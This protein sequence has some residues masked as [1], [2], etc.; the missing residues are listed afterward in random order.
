MSRPQAMLA[1]SVS[2]PVGASLTLAN[3]EAQSFMYFREYTTREI[4]FNSPTRNT[5]FSMRHARGKSPSLEL[6]SLTEA[7]HVFALRQYVKAMGHLRTRLAEIGGGRQAAEIALV[8]CVLFVCLEM[9]QGNRVGALV[10]LR[11]GLSVLSGMPSQVH[12]GHSRGCDYLVVKQERQALVDQLT[13]IFA[14]LDIDTMSFGERAPVFRIVSPEDIIGIELVLPAD[15]Q[16]VDQALYILDRLN[17]TVHHVRG[18]LLELSSQSC[19]SEKLNWAVRCCLEYA[20]IRK[21][22]PSQDPAAF[23]QL[24]IL[25]TNLAQ[26]LLAFQRLTVKKGVSSDKGAAAAIL[27]EIRYFYMFFQRFTCRNYIETSYDQFNSMFE[28]IVLLC[29][30]LVDGM[31]PSNTTPLTTPE[32]TF[33]LDSGAIPSLYLTAIKCRESSIRR[34]AI[35]LLHRYP[36]QEGMWEPTMI[37]KYVEEI[38]NLEERA[39]ASTKKDISTPLK[40]KDVTEASR[41]SDVILAATENPQLGR[42]VCAR[43]LQET[44]GGL[45]SW[46]I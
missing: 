3:I 18:R 7:H 42:L 9:L 46:S 16:S 31:S 33:T 17:S 25:H 8:A 38:V 13:D 44:T 32:V 23:A 43:F 21:V 22:N 11:N 1:A 45:L 12:R 6:F 39:A 15:F 26:W 19:S 2:A 5:L 40:C 35:S 24:A 34:E 20:S 29:R 14:R 10:H 28:R 37:A 41:F 36:C 27:V 30:M 4:P